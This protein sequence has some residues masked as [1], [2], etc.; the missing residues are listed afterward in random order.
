MLLPYRIRA[1]ARGHPRVLALSY[2]GRAAYRF[3]Y[4]SLPH[5]LCLLS[6]RRRRLSSVHGSRLASQGEDLVSGNMGSR[7]VG[8]LDSVVMTLILSV[9]SGTRVHACTSV[10]EH[11]ACQVGTQMR[12]R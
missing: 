5:P 12:E 6:P 3:A 7:V 1:L 2:L 10:K 8:Q 9:R 4:L 11:M